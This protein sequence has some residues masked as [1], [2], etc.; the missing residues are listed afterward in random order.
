M[1]KVTLRGKENKRIRSISFLV[2]SQCIQVTCEACPSQ[3]VTG[4]VNNIL[5]SIILSKN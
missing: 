1:D 3:A 5:L 4:R 2:S